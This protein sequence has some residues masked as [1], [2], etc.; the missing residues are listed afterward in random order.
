MDIFSDNNSLNLILLALLFLSN[1]SLLLGEGKGLFSL[2]VIL[3]W[4]IRSSFKSIVI[5]F[6]FIFL[7]NCIE[8]NK[9]INVSFLVI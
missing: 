4:L 5:S 8:L 2:C 1:N 3:N 6:G 7:L 9:I